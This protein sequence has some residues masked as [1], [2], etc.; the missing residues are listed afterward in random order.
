MEPQ[1]L[2]LLILF[3]KGYGVFAKQ[4]KIKK[5]LIL[6]NRVKFHQMKKEDDFKTKIFLNLIII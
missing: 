6:F 3:I 5:L 1:N 2:L 4:D